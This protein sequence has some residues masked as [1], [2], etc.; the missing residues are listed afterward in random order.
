MPPPFL[1][2]M[3]KK[4]QARNSEMGV[5]PVETCIVNDAHGSQRDMCGR[6]A[7]EGREFSGPACIGHLCQHVSSNGHRCKKMPERLDKGTI[8]ANGGWFPDLS[9]ST[10]CRRH[11]KYNCIQLINNSVRCSGAKVSGLDYCASHA[12]LMCKWEEPVER[13]ECGRLAY[14]GSKYCTVHC[15]YDFHLFAQTEM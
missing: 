4:H 3:W 13:R 12:A 1:I 8:R 11:E 10:N 5:R 15:W 2:F 9:R 7:A 14:P 6:P